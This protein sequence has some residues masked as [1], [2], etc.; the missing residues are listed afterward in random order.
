MIRNRLIPAVLALAIVFAA[1]V[2]PGHADA[3]PADSG[4]SSRP[5]SAYRLA[6]TPVYQL[7]TDLDSGGRFDVQGHFLRFGII[8]ALDWSG[9]TGAETGESRS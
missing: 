8:P 2:L 3:H 4:E 9:A 5:K 7:A 6:Y 1:T